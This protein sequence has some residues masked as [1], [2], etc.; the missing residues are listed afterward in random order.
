M[1]RRCLRRFVSN[2][3][4]FVQ[5]LEDM[6]IE[7]F[8]ET[9]YSFIHRPNLPLNGQL[10][11]RDIFPKIMIGEHLCIVLKTKSRNSSYTIDSVVLEFF[12][13]NFSELISSERQYY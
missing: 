4:L 11:E 3:I 13:Y 1:Q 7:W 2:G 12:N 6:P 8:I 10:P 5:D 9:R